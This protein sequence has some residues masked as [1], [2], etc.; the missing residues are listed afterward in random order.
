M[1]TIAL[2]VLL[3]LAGA[4]GLA[5]GHH[6]R[7]RE[8]AAHA[9]ALTGGDAARGAA[10][11]RS[12]GCVACHLMPHVTGPDSRAGPPLAHFA[13]RRYVAGA[14]ENTP[15]NVIHFLR[16]PRSVAPKSAMP[17]LHLFDR[18]ARDLAAYLYT[19]R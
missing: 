9:N 3:L 15:D 6:F 13:V 16:E 17:N 10:L 18:D 11:A 19:L 8:A 5:I 14:A 2:I 7:N 1:R 12:A 4:I